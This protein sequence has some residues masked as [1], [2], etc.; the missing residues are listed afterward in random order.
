MQTGDM[1]S[2]ESIEHLDTNISGLLINFEKMVRGCS[3]FGR[4]RSA[5][6]LHM[7]LAHDL[8]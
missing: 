4:W 2:L 7:K 3:F 5:T 8:K 1:Y 6:K